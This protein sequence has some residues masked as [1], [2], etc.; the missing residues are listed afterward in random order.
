MLCD[1]ETTAAELSDKLPTEK[2][3][4]IDV[5][6]SRTN[7]RKSSTGLLNRSVERD[8]FHAVASDTPVRHSQDHPIHSNPPVYKEMLLSHLPS[9]NANAIFILRFLWPA[10]PDNHLYSLMR[11]VVKGRSMSSTARA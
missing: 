7:A 1:A 5:C 9:T 4:E 6:V 11:T 10:V 3:G 2:I 8:R